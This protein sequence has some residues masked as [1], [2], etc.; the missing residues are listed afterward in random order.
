MNEPDMIASTAELA[1]KRR[2]WIWL[3]SIG[4]AVL[5][6]AV[7]GWITVNAM[8]SKS[9]KEAYLLA[10]WRAI[11]SEQKV[12]KGAL[13]DEQLR[14]ALADRANDFVLE[15]D[16]DI[17]A[18]LRDEDDKEE[19][20]TVGEIIENLTL[21]L[22][23]REHSSEQ[24][25]DYTVQLLQHDESLIDL[26]IAAD[27]EK[28][29]LSSEELF[30]D[31]YYVNRAEIDDWIAELREI[32]AQLEMQDKFEGLFELTE[33]EWDSLRSRYGSILL[34][35]IGR[36]FILDHYA[37]II[38][39]FHIEGR[40]HIIRQSPILRHPSRSLYF[41]I[42]LRASEIRI[43]ADLPLDDRIP[44]GQI[45]FNLKSTD[46][47]L[48]QHRSFRFIQAIFDD[49]SQVLSIYIFHHILQ[50]WIDRQE[51]IDPIYKHLLKFM[52]SA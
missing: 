37:V 1:P 26:N 34:D 49:L 46:R 15:L 42:E 16:A 52:V 25:G 24:W 2:W 4:V 8:I 51:G 18:Q 40:L 36:S 22:S 3:V 48:H 20:R 14:E 30:E 10:E 38:P 43:I 13:Q 17:D 23:G 39:I 29:S 50:V 41:Q 7:G 33:E 28:Y 31:T 21:R 44:F 9:P 47:A 32:E 45:S 19:F 35:R 5:V 6:L 27:R 12:A 11:S